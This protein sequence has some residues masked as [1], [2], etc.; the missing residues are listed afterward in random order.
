MNI[1][2]NLT[3]KD[4]EVVTSNRDQSTV[5]KTETPQTDKT[6]S[7]E[8]EKPNDVTAEI[9]AVPVKKADID[10]SKK[11]SDTSIKKPV[12]VSIKQK[13]ADSSQK[14]A[15]DKTVQKTSDDK[16]VVKTPIPTDKK[17]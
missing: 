16:T 17:V 2:P 5:K 10:A 8:P 9:L 12:D 13:V 1:N 3:T 6:S 4:S 15:T 7:S 14:P 11:S